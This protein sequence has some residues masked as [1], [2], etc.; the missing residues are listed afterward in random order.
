MC[1]RSQVCPPPPPPPTLS[2]LP[3]SPP[4]PPSAPVWPLTVHARVA[5]L[6][7]GSGLVSAGADGKV[8]SYAHVAADSR[9]EAG[10]WVVAGSHRGHTHDVRGVA[11]SPSGLVVRARAAAAARVR[12][13]PSPA[14]VS[15]GV[16]TRL[17]VTPLAL[18]GRRAPRKIGACAR[19]PQPALRA[20]T[21]RAR[22]GPF[23]CTSAVSLAPAARLLLVRQA[24]A[25]QLFRLAPR[26]AAVGAA[27]ASCAPP[28]LL[29][30]RC[31]Y[32]G[33][34]ADADATPRAPRRP[35]AKAVPLATVVS[36]RP[37]CPP[38]ERWG[39]GGGGGQRRSPRGTG[40]AA[41]RAGADAQREAGCYHRVQVR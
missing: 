2:P 17:C 16:D 7:D 12:V 31:C 15:G 26:P 20:D 36:P 40:V 1:L 24:H 18:L 35:G 11:V 32:S 8:V 22:A 14:Q 3:P 4:P 9:G 19:A 34:G 33:A 28:L 6:P 39:W 23:P 25:L 27:G 37:R 30:L 41:A 21:P 13:R 29:L 5:A 38:R 10:A